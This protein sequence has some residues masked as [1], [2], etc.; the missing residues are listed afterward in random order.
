MRW[1][2]QLGGV[3]RFDD[4][5]HLIGGLISLHVEHVV[6]ARS[7][8]LRPRTSRA[9]TSRRGRLINGVVEK[10]R[11]QS[12]QLENASLRRGHE[13]VDEAGPENERLRVVRMPRVDGLHERLVG[14]RERHDETRVLREQ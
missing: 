7:F 14:A 11:V 1:Q 9:H 13:N 10:V 4:A 8:V 5:A 12:A 2:P 3:H 6:R